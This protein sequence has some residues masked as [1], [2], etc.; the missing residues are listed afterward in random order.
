MQHFSQ[1][2]PRVCTSVLFIIII[3]NTIVQPESFRS[4][5]QNAIVFACRNRPR[6]ERNDEFACIYL[7]SRLLSFAS[8]VRNRPRVHARTYVYIYTVR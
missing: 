2:A 5:A 3:N 8:T 7:R 1:I 6:V 4:N